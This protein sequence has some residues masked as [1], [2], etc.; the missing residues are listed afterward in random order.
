MLNLIKLL[1]LTPVYRNCGDK[2]HFKWH[3]KVMF[4]Q[5]PRVV[6]ST[7]WLSLR[8]NRSTAQKKWGSGESPAAGDK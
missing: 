7:R 8:L 2:D 6:Y 4:S 1:S 3:H 5:F